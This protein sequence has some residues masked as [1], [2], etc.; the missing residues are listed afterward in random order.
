MEPL[1][2]VLTAELLPPLHEELTTLL[3]GLAPDDWERPTVAGAW[4]VRDVAAHL[5]DGDLRTLAAY[6]DGYS[7]PPPEPIAG[8]ADLVRFLDGLNAGW[9]RAAERLSPL[10]LVELLEWTGPRVSAALAARPDHAEAVYPVA[11]AGEERSEH[12]MDVGRQY[13]ERWHHQQQVRDAVGAPL[14]LAGR[15]LLPLLDLSV[16]ALP[17][18]YAEVSAPEGTALVLRVRGAEGGPGAAWSLARDGVGWTLA[19]GEA[20]DPAA[21]IEVDADTAWR[22]L[23]NALSAEEA[24]GRAAVHG[25]AALAEPLF[26]ARSVMV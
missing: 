4:R 1:S 16:R 7:P 12:W 23:Y 3:R 26:A 25:D 20:P 15:W 10:L 24:R 18:A 19:R 14:L 13:T 6:R 5:L 9:V 17:R 11:W 21:A 8:Y 2:P 22:L